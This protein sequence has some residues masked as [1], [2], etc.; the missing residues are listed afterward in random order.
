MW[1][2]PEKN[3]QKLAQQCKL[4]HSNVLPAHEMTRSPFAGFSPIVIP[5]ENFKW[6]AHYRLWVSNLRE[7]RFS[8][9]LENFFHISPLDLEAFQFHFH[10]SKRVKS[11]INSLFI[12]RKEW[13][14]KWFHFSFLEKSESNSNFTLFSREKRV[15]SH[16]CNCAFWLNFDAKHKKMQQ[17]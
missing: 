2:I 15:K 4:D 1:G 5:I 10:F 14:G 3:Y 12:S 8:R 13:K 11:K 7:S 17:I 16:K 6:V 9:I